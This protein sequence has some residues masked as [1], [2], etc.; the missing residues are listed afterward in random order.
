LKR[1]L[2]A[3]PKKHSKNSE[4][5]CSSKPVCHQENNKKI[6]IEGYMLYAAHEWAFQ[7][8]NEEKNKQKESGGTNN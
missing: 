8:P 2:D 1:E 4:Q 6:K 3:E 5:A 7:I